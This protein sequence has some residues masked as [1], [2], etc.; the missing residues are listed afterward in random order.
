MDVTV[1]SRF[2]ENVTQLVKTNKYQVLELFRKAFSLYLK[3]KPDSWFEDILNTN[4][5]FEDDIGF[6]TFLAFMS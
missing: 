2:R 1:I 3:S 4:T 6:I 5:R